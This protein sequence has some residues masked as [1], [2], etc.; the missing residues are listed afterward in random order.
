MKTK[1]K[2]YKQLGK[3]IN[4]IDLKYIIE[5]KLGVNLHLKTR[6]R[7]IVDARRMF[8]YLARRHTRF[9]LSILGG[10]FDLDHAT[11]LH[12]INSAKDLIKTDE[13]FREILYNLEQLVL[14]KKEKNYN[15]QFTQIPKVIHPHRLRYAQKPLRQILIKRR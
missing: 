1:L 15:K 9:G 11:A 3:D 5:R 12:G 14:E 7:H 4:L 10:F 6:K 13:E 2:R 8:F